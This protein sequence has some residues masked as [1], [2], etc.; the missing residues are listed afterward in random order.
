MA[1]SVPLVPLLDRHKKFADEYLRTRNASGS[2]R[3]AGASPKSCHVTAQKWLK[4]PDVTEYLRIRVAQLSAPKAEAAEQGNDLDNRI[5]QELSTLAF[6]NIAD[7]ITI[8]EDG[9]PKFDLSTATPEQLSA[10]SNLKTKTTRRYDPKGAH[11]A[12]DTELAI[13]IADKYRGLE[14]LGKHR[15]LF[16]ADEQRV[17]LDVADRLLNARRRLALLGD[18]GRITL[19]DGHRGER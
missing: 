5:I 7:L 11:I 15:G 8:D 13:S 17:V 9:Q 19:E 4:R 2:A 6:A 10:I 12:T 1:K 18:E 14:L 3:L 16:K